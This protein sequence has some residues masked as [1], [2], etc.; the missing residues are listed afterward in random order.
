ML[1]RA[2]KLE[3]LGLADQ[4]GPASWT[5]K[6]G[7]EQSLRELSIRDDIIKTVNKALAV[8]LLLGEVALEQRFQTIRRKQLIGQV[9]QHHVV[10]MV[11][12]HS[13]T[14]TSGLALLHC[15]R[16]GVVEVGAAF[17]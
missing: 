15:A 16:T 6:P 1:G 5:L 4:I 9:A 3:R 12:A 13:S 10:Q 14:L 11:H 7:L 8:I 2:K 17:A